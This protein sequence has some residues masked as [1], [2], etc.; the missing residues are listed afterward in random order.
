T[1]SLS[2][3][4]WNSRLLC[5]PSSTDGTTSTRTPPTPAGSSTGTQWTRATSGAAA[6]A[7]FSLVAAVSA[8][9]P[10]AAGPRRSGQVLVVLGGDR[11]LA[12]AQQ[13]GAAQLG[14]LDVLAVGAALRRAAVGGGG[15]R[16][17]R[18]LE[19]A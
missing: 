7:R 16:R 12:G 1:S 19:H 8:L 11:S 6:R 5:S 14:V 13:Q 4:W 15:H 3:S 18:A 17:P 10:G 9:R 2:M